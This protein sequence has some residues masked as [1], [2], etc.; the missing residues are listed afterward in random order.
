M[1]WSSWG[2]ELY[3]WVSSR[4]PLFGANSTLG[5]SSGRRRFVAF[6]LG[7]SDLHVRGA[8]RVGADRR[9]LRH[10]VAGRRP[11]GVGRAAPVPRLRAVLAGGLARGDRRRNDPLP[12]RAELGAT[13]ARDRPRRHA[14]RVLLVAPRGPPRRAARAQDRLPQDGLHAQASERHELLHR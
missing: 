4:A 12:A 14:A 13:A 1:W 11:R 10:A 7:S 6:E 2:R 3:S 8:A 5:L 9:R